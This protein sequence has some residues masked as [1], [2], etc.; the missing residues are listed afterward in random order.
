MSR[1]AASQAVCGQKSRQCS[2]E[3]PCGGAHGGSTERQLGPLDRQSQRDPSTMLSCRGVAPREVAAQPRTQ[4]SPA[5]RT[6]HDGPLTAAVPG[7]AAGPQR[8]IAAEP[9]H[10]AR[11]RIG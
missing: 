6:A 11:P 3:R 5:T 2:T 9:R 8:A 1:S 10:A 4:C 7:P